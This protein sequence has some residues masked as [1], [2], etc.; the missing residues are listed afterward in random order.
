MTGHTPW[1]LLRDRKREPSPK[2]LTRRQRL[3]DWWLALR[4]RYTSCRRY[5]HMAIEGWDYCM[6]CGQTRRRW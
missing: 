4:V 1:H 5:G 6:N 2:T 3:Y